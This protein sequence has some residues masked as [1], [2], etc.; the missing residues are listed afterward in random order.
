MSPWPRTW[1]SGC[2]GLLCSASKAS[3]A[4]GMRTEGSGHLVL[5]DGRFRFLLGVNYWPR[6]LNIRMWRDW[7]EEAI[8]KDL[9]QMKE[10][11]VR[12]ARVFLL[13]QDFVTPSGDV[14]SRSVSRLRWLLDEMGRRRVGAMVTLLVGHMSGRNW[15][16][17]W[18]PG[19][20]VYSPQAVDFTARLASRLAS[21][22]SSSEGLAGWILS[23]E[24]S[25]FRRASRPEEE[26]TLLRAFRDSVKAVDGSH[27]IGSGDVPDSYAQRPHLV[28]GLVDYIGPHLYLYDADEVRHGYSYSGMLE[29]FSDDGQQPVILEEFGFSS[30]QFSEEDRAGFIYEVLY[31]ALAHLAS[32]ALVWC[33][34]D[35]PDESDPPYLWRGLELGFGLVDRDGRPKPSAEAFRR[36]ASELSAIESLGLSRPRRTSRALV[37][38]PFYIMGDYE[39]AIYRE[40]LGGLLGAARPVL[41]AHQLLTMAGAQ[42]SI[43][44][45]AELSLPEARRLVVVPSAVSMLT[46]TWR[47]LLSYVESGGTLVA[48]LVRGVGGSWF[49]HES[50]THLWRELFGVE[51]AMRSGSPGEPL[52]GEVSLRLE[53]GIGGL[54]PGWSLG[55]RFERPVL[56][57]RVRQA[58]AEVI[59]E[60]GGEPAAFM[61]RRGRGRAM[62]FTVPLEAALAYS[63][64]VG[65]WSKYAE[66]YSAI[67]REAGVDLMGPG[68]PR[69]EVQEVVD[70]GLRLVIAVNHSASSAEV[71]QPWLSG[72]REVSGNGELRGGRLLLPPRG[73]VAL[74]NR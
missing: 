28:R 15:A 21:E 56:A 1:A 38:A 37:L 67:A 35:F 6:L 29:L 51:P 27:V 31:T 60:A 23:N 45:E 57:Y 33:F 52:E 14:D 22:L 73:A 2:S 66:L 9:D 63:F 11:G 25:L 68:D 61:A 7:D 24:L 30:L 58:D 26:L 70:G 54:G 49:P 69:V 4:P 18:A 10:L 32:G 53:E 39:F 59:A 20:D 50:G 62:L 36:F 12:V 48:S 8:Q 17:P 46:T 55:L 42:A 16:I 41:V 34:S 13:D 40:P 19:G 65:D 47:S 44:Y 3:A 64:R 71:S 5:T 74:A 43:R 72:L